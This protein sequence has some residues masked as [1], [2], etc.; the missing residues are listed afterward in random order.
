MLAL[1][2][3]HSFEN[4]C[5][6][7]ANTF[8]YTEVKGDKR[9]F[10]QSHEAR[11][12]PKQNHCHNVLCCDGALC[13]KVIRRATGEDVARHSTTEPQPLTPQH[14]LK[15]HANYFC[16][17][18]SY[19]LT[20]QHALIGSWRWKNWITSINNM[21]TSNSGRATVDGWIKLQLGETLVMHY[22]LENTPPAVQCRSTVHCQESWVQYGDGRWKRWHVVTGTVW[23]GK[24]LI[25]CTWSWNGYVQYM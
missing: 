7:D 18:I 20:T 16:S 5:F 19:T 2:L 22:T 3:K 14:A 4:C 6:K 13:W 24:L 25:Y 8:K 11:I 15:H 1:M 21:A 12:E 17:W 23:D 10:E 9:G